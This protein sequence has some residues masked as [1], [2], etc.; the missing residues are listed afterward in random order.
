MCCFRPL[1]FPTRIR[2]RNSICIMIL[3]WIVLMGV[4]I[5]MAWKEQSHRSLEAHLSQK[6][7]EQ[8]LMWHIWTRI[9]LMGWFWWSLIARTHMLISAC[10][11]P[12][13]PFLWSLF[14]LAWWW[15]VEWLLG[16]SVDFDNINITINSMKKLW[17]K[18][19]R[20]FQ[21]PL[22]RKVRMFHVL[23][24]NLLSPSHRWMKIYK[25]LITRNKSKMIHED[26]VF[27]V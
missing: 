26:I 23:K 19:H 12:Q 2:F 17:F 24:N 18:T 15:L 1:S 16:F 4:S 25:Y 27:H 9:H 8:N 11:N 6:L 3:L 20:Q 13:H 14:G 10:I 21:K 5:S 22:I 7:M